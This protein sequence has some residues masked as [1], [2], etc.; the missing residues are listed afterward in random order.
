MSNHC[1]NW[2]SISADPCQ[3]IA[4][5][6]LNNGNYV[7][8]GLSKANYLLLIAQCGTTSAVD[9]LAPILNQLVALATSS[10]TEL[11][12]INANTVN[13]E[14]QL[15]AVITL[16][17]AG[18]ATSTDILTAV[19][20]ILVETIAIN[21][22]TDG[23]EAL[24]TTMITLLTTISTDVADIEVLVTTGNALLTAI[25]LNL[26]QIEVLVTA[27]NASLVSIDA[28][29]TASNVLLA[30]IDT[31]LSSMEALLVSIDSSI[32]AIE[33][34]I[35]SIL[36]NQIDPALFGTHTIITGTEAAAPVVGGY[37]SWVVVRT[38]GTGALTVDGLP[39]NSTGDSTSD[40]ALPQ[41]KIPEPTI[42][43]AVDATYAW[44]TKS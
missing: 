44:K 41:F 12:A 25:D 27:G 18:N 35:A 38:G 30:A 13:Q 11:I 1:C 31:T 16:L 2:D 28:L 15:D 26:D 43:V 9:D 6:V 32:T 36:A 14:T 33:T 34:D 22:N 7:N 10:L 39:L 20:A 29:I 24:L 19:Q 37:S 40:E 4:D 17:T 3:A 42:V 8:F 5:G 23:I 21:A